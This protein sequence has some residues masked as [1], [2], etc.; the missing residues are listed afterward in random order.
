[1][2]EYVVNDVMPHIPFWTLRKTFLKKLGLSIGSGSFI[3]KD[4]YFLS[5]P[6]ISIGK[7]SHI[8][9]GCLLDGRGSIAIGNSVSVSFGVKL[10]SGGHDLQSETFFAKEPKDLTVEES[11]T[12]VPG[13]TTYGLELMLLCFRMCI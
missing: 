9:K 6:K 5:L 10:L 12:E 13:M 8:N 1:M 3:M 2:L 11:A 4:V 7:H